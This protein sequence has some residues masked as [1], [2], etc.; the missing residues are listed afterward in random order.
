MMSRNKKNILKFSVATLAIAA[1]TYC[2][3][4]EPKNGYHIAGI[5]VS[6]IVFLWYC[7]HVFTDE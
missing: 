5:I 2:I 1:F 7:W 6:I 3:S 4:R